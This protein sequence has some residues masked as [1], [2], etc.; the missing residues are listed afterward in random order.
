MPL[1]KL[2]SKKESSHKLGI[3]LRQNSLTYCYMPEQGSGICQKAD[4]LAG[5]Y[6]NSLA[7]LKSNHGLE[8]GQCHLVLSAQQSQIVQIEKPKVPDNE[9]HAALKW[10]VKDLVNYS[11]D[12]MVLDYY[13][14]PES[15]GGAEK[16]NVVCA[17]KSDLKE[18]V[19]QLINDGFSVKSIITEEFAFAGLLPVQDGACLLICQQPNEEILLLIVKQGQLYF[20]RRL[21]GFMQIGTKSE[22]ELSMGIID[23]L[24]LEVQRSTDYFER[25]LKQAPIHS[26]KI[27][28]PIKNETFLARKLAEN[29]NVAVELLSLPDGYE[30][31]REFAAA[32]GATRT[33]FVES[34]T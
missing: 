23:A 4:L 32:I 26:I 18:M 10:Q 11:P 8:E 34:N 28:V 16:I 13:D 6:V 31:Q 1:R 15:A 19:E 5:S 17:A 22:E 20:F 33:H 29:T 9:I 3:T 21:R 24:S 30:E 14:G 2:F 25:Q 7:S 27:I 12:N